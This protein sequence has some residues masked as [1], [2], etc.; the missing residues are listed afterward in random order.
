MDLISKTRDLGYNIFDLN[1]SFYNDICSIFIYNN[2]DFSLSERK[3]LLDLSDEN[4]TVP[5]CYYTSFDIET[6]RT[7]Y[8]C[9]IGNEINGN[10]SISEIIINDN[11]DNN[12]F[13]K[14]K[15]QKYFSKYSTIEVIKCFSIILNS[16]LFTENYGFY[17]MFFMNIL[18]ILLFIFSFSSKLEKQLNVICNT[19]LSQMKKLYNKKPNEINLKIDNIKINENSYIVNDKTIDIDNNKRMNINT[20]SKNDNTHISDNYEKVIENN[21]NN[22]LF[23]DKQRN[24]LTSKIESNKESKNNSYNNENF[25]EVIIDNSK[26]EASNINNNELIF[27]TNKNEN[28]K[29][30]SLDISKIENLKENSSQ[31]VWKTKKNKINPIKNRDTNSINIDSSIKMKKD[32]SNILIN[33]LSNI[34]DDINK[35]NYNGDDEKKII[36]ELRKKYNSN[37]YLFYIIK[38]IPIKKRKKYLSELEMENLPYD[39]ALKIEDRNKS[40]FYFSLLR[41][42]NKIISIFLNDKD[43]NIQNAKIAL[44]IFHFNLSF[45]IN[46]IF[47]TEETIYLINQDKGSSLNLRTQISRIVYS[48]IISRV[49]VYI[50][51]L[52]FFIHNSIIKLRYYED[53]KKAEDS[54]PTLL[55]I[56]KIKIMVFFII[57]TFFDIIFFYYIT[58]FCSVYSKIQIHLIKDSFICFLLINLYSVIL[59]IFV[60][61][62]RIFSLKKKSK[63]RYL[64][65]LISWIISLI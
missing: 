24:T 6:I 54:V 60:S 26:N 12:F 18:N 31:R 37:L 13:V 46:T 22:N 59:F 62:I 57:V 44:F 56:L 34:N 21:K 35:S 47:F 51:E 9:K 43:F 58:A 14:L 20:I 49:I 15:K 2:T 50:V 7:I 45:A 16:K 52:L 64:L 10:N 28:N 5:G 4:L 36:E 65:Y 48:A 30:F 33:N 25:K 1:N 19:L 53:I 42:K 61:S 29:N 40:D 27:N 63:F 41:E 17:I 8:L 3:T 39:Y 55:R 38:Y 32:N 23:K 11:D